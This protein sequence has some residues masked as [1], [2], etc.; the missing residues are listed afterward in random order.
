[1]ESIID[2]GEDGVVPMIE[3]DEVGDVIDSILEYVDARFE[4]LDKQDC[5][6]EILALCQ[7]F[8]EWGAAEGG[9]QI[10]YYV[11]PTFE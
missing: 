9:E 4:I 8:Y 3:S 11:C 6:N 1:M 7:E 2:Y 5:Q 10:S